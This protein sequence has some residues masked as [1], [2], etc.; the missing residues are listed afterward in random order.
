MAADTGG[1][2]MESTQGH[3]GDEA[4]ILRRCRGLQG[5]A[6]CDRVRQ[7]AQH[8]A[9]PA[10]ERPARSDHGEKAS[11]YTVECRELAAARNLVLSGDVRKSDVAGSATRPAVRSHLSRSYL[12]RMYI[13]SSAESGTQRRSA[14]W[15]SRRVVSSAWPWG[16]GETSPAAFAKPRHGPRPGCR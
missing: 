15:P 11:R 8:G 13:T 12:A 4:D 5:Q 10:A 14:A 9:S 2:T 7:G 6:Q 1:P 16:A 3:G